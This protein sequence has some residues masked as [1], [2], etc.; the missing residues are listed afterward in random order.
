MF[1]EIYFIEEDGNQKICRSIYKCF[2][3]FFMHSFVVNVKTSNEKNINQFS[4]MFLNY[5]MNFF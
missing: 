1:K 4:I 5:Q 2:F 3:N